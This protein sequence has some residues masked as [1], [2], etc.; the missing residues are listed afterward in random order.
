MQHTFKEKLSKAQGRSEFTIVVNADIRGF[1]AFSTVNESP[2]IAMFIKRFYHQMIDTYFPNANFVKPTGDGL[3][4]T[5]PYGE[6]TLL[7]VSKAVL[8]SCHKCLQ[9]FPD[10]CVNDPMI[11]FAVPDH[12]GF[13][14]ARGTACCLYSGNEILDYSG[15][16]L[17]LASRLMELARPSGIVVDS[18]YLK[19]VIPDEL[20][21]LF[22]EREVYLRSISEEHPTSVLYL[23][24]IVNIPEFYLSPLLTE[25]WVTS[26]HQFT[27]REF[28]KI[29]P[30]HHGF[31][32]KSKP[33]SPEKIRVT[34]IYPVKNFKGRSIETPIFDFE[35]DENS[36]VPSLIVPIQQWIKLITKEELSPNMKISFRTEYVPKSLTAHKQKAK[37]TA[38][39]KRR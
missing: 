6:D 5:F 27:V 16:L 13:G 4:M 8:T 1:S 30:L 15:H 12:I 10:F 21:E 37:K 7:D 23:K 19:T 11:N 20:R 25:T 9:E 38:S 32:L 33:K 29:K 34:F 26:E 36:P 3:L 31:R 17:N 14:V 22:A 39:K 18:N 24:G 28:L 2:N 35:Y